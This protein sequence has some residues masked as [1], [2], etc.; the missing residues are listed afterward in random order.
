VVGFLGGSVSTQPHLLAVGLMRGSL[1]SLLL[2][3]K[4]SPIDFIKS[5][6]DVEIAKTTLRSLKDIIWYLVG[7]SAGL[8]QLH[9]HGIVHCDTAARNFLVDFNNNCCVCDFGM[10]QFLPEGQSTVHT[11]FD[12]NIPL[13]WC[14]PETLIK[15]EWSI[16]TDVYSFG[17]MIVELMTRNAP[18]PGEKLLDV[19]PRIL[20]ARNPYRPHIAGWWPSD[21]ADLATE[22]MLHQP[23]DRPTMMSVNKKLHRFHERLM[24]A[25]VLSDVYLPLKPTK[26]GMNQHTYTPTPSSQYYL[27]FKSLTLS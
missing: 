9:A 27:Q 15:R 24:S 12:D 17:V 14:A 8:V 18:Y 16:K 22:C 21:L 7:A 6:H 20:N 10:S 19:V 3:N 13:A 23:H 11:S 26:E 5:K 4:E 2:I 25:D 1:E